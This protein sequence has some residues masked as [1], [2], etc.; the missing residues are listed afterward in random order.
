MFVGLRKVEDGFQPM[1]ISLPNPA[2][3]ELG[4][5]NWDEVFEMAHKW[6]S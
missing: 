1:I 6:F 4:S 2:V 5:D 3:V